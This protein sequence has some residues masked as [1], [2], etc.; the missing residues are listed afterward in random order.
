MLKVY[1]VYSESHQNLFDNYFF[2]SLK[3]TDLELHV[4]KFHQKGS[5]EFLQEDY[6]KG[7][8]YKVDVIIRAIQENY[9]DIF[10]FSDV[11]IIFFHKVSRDLISLLGDKDIVFLSDNYRKSIACTGFFI[12]RGNIKTLNLWKE[13]KKRLE[14]AIAQNI[15]MHDQ[16]F[17][18]KIL[19]EKPKTI[20]FKY[21]PLDRYYCPRGFL[22]LEK[23]SPIPHNIYIYHANWIV[24]T[25]NVSWV[26]HKELLL[27]TVQEALH[28]HR[29]TS[30]L[31][32]FIRYFSSLPFRI[33][34]Y[35]LS[36]I[37]KFISSWN[38][39][40]NKDSIRTQH[41]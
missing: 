39:S 18:N 40:C 37:R 8:L 10:V 12:C 19:H 36:V 13:C 26:R 17:I 28:N 11:D 7:I 6:L 30:P 22:R 41:P 14:Y 31:L 15:K 27:D 32:Y 9:N 5:W 21:L 34:M 1:A 25:Q 24:K 3:N 23:I 16:D 35:Y 38:I 33:C 2:P 4:S 20:K 29:G